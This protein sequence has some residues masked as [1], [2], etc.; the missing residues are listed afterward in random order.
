MSGRRR[1][2]VCSPCLSLSPS[3]FC[4][5][6]G[7]GEDQDQ[8][9]N[10]EL[11]K[12]KGELWGPHQKA[13][14]ISKYTPKLHLQDT[15][16]K[17]WSRSQD[18]G[19]CDWWVAGMNATSSQTGQTLFRLASLFFLVLFWQRGYQ[20]PEFHILPT[21]PGFPGLLFTPSLPPGPCCR[22]SQMT[23][24]LPGALP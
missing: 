10:E 19:K 7:G 8:D 20:I 13:T 22:H 3:T 14:R 17:C 5:W 23:S 24:E 1:T 2:L 21:F 15:A 12:T 18:S 6:A 11:G 16:S 4:V 9:Q